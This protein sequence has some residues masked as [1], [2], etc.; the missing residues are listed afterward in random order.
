MTGRRALLEGHGGK[1]VGCQIVHPVQGG[2]PAPGFTL[3]GEPACC[4]SRS[5]LR[6]GRGS[7]WLLAESSAACVPLHS[8]VEGGSG[9]HGSISLSSLLSL[10][11]SAEK[12]S[13]SSAMSLPNTS[14]CCDG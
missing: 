12:F 14:G 3:S 6:V 10:P 5:I 8:G 4:S 2:V 1:G 7:F 13:E 11:G 9:L